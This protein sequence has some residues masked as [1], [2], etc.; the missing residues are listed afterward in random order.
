MMRQFSLICFLTVIIQFSAY[1]Q[2]RWVKHY[3]DNYNSPVLDLNIAYDNGYLLSGWITPNYPPYSWLI[4]TDINGGVLWLKLVGGIN[5]HSVC[6]YKSCQN[7]IGEIFL[8]G[9]IISSDDANPII[10]KLNACGEKEWCRELTTISNND[11][12]WDVVYTNDGGCAA[13]VYG[14]FSPL[15]N[16]AGILKFSSNGDLLWQ[17]YYQSDDSGIGS[18]ELSNLIRTP[19]EGFLMTGWCYYPDPDTTLA[20]LHP[21]YVKTD[22]LGNFEWETIVHKETG[23]VGGEAFM[24][25]VNPSQTYF[26]SCISHYYTSDTLYTTRPAIVKLDLQGNVMGVYD[27]VHGNYDLGKIATFDF[28]NDSLMVGSAGWGNEDDDLQSRVIIFDSLENMRDSATLFHDVYLGYTKTTYDDKIVILM[29]DHTSGQFKPTLFKLTQDLEED[30]FYTTPFVYDSLCPYQIA[31]DTIVPD[32]CGVIVGIEEDGKTVGLYDGKK[33]G[34]EIW[35][36]PAKEMLNVECLMLNEGKDYSIS[37][38]DIFGREIQAEM[39]TSTR[40]GGWKG[41]IN[42]ESFPPGVYIAI[43]KKGFDFVESRKFVVAR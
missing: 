33:G 3:M 4:K 11:T 17:Q 21:Y 14:A 22:S 39:I 32:D 16:R 35:P 26:Y 23:D 15:L 40:E 37:I 9:C 5:G 10:V 28:L 18:P 20:W 7:L 27:L 29:S 6:I 1:S 42:V 31:S 19:D 8:C 24:S 34:L 12:F 2:S 41:Q 13:L 30:T 38:Y 25:L 43:L 36:N